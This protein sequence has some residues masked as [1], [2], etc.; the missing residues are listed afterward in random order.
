MSY[1]KILKIIV[2]V[3]SSV[4]LEYP[5]DN[6]VSVWLK[7]AN[8]PYLQSK[9]LLLTVVV[10]LILLFA[11]LPYTILRF[12]WRRYFRL[13]RRLRPLLESYYG[14]YEIHTRYWTGFLLLVRCCYGVSA[15]ED[16]GIDL[17]SHDPTKLVTKTH[18]DL[19]EPLLDD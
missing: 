8:V 19:Q 10:T 3:Y 12:S 11:F 14:P 1:T 16:D 7:D 13:L 17:S 9:H 18:I 2:E 15:G 6:T 4:D 5:N